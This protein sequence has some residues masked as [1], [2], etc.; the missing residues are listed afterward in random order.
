MTTRLNFL[1]ASLLSV[2][3]SCAS[4][5]HP[6]P[7]RQIQ[8]NLQSLAHDRADSFYTGCMD[9]LVAMHELGYRNDKDLDN[10]IGFKTYQRRCVDQRWNYY[11]YLL[12]ALQPWWHFPWQ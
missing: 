10:G 7:D 1:Y 4:L 5:P 11:H 2:L 12:K 6:A 8:G 9:G 3:T